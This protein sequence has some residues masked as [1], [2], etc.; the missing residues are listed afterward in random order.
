MPISTAAAT[1]E[2][3]P[4]VW[5]DL[6]TYDYTL[7][8]EFI[9]PLE[10]AVQRHGCAPQSL[11]LALLQRLHW[12]FT[13]DLRSRAPT[14]ALTASQAPAFHDRVRQ[15]M[16]HIDAATLETL[17]PQQVSTEVRHALLSYQDPVLHSSVTADA[18]DHEQGLVRLSYYVHGDPPTETF[19]IDEV[20]VAPAYAKYR[21]C[22]YYHRIL[23]RQRIVWL[24]V[25]SA[26][27][28]R[29]TLGGKLVPLAV[30]SQPFAVGSAPERMGLTADEVLPAARA[31]YPPGKGGQQP[32]PGGWRG[33][34]VRLLLGL[35]RL[36]WARQKFARAWVFA[37]REAGADDNA[38]HLYR[39]VREHHPEINAWFMLGRSS[40]DWDRLARDGFRLI[41]EGLTR[42][43]LILNCEHI[44]SSHADYHFGRFD[45]RLYGNALRWRY[46]FLQHGVIQNDLSHWLGPGEF[47]RF[48]TSS[49]AE[50]ESVVGDD[51]AYPY[52]DR[53]VRRT[54]LPRH[55][56]LLQ[57]A[58]RTPAA[59]VNTLLVMPTWRAG[60][61]DERVAQSSAAGRMAAFAA[62]EYAKHWRALL[63]NDELHDLAER[64]GQRIVFMPH[65]DAAPYID[66]FD[67]PAGVSV[68]MARNNS[69]Q[70][71]FARSAGF[72]TDYTSVAFDMAFLRRPVFYYQ[73]DRE[74]F[75]S[76]GH[77]WREGYFD[78]QR[79]G[80]G[81][82]ALTE[83]ELLG[84]LR[85]YFLNEAKPEPG[86]L[87]RMERA[88]PGRDDQACRRVFASILELH[89]PVATARPEIQLSAE[90]QR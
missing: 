55:D 47:D 54:G 65:F 43:L 3:S 2:P 69:L 40:P 8:R 86:Y 35:A 84:H 14:V 66:A 41:P 10:E 87:A 77:N 24:S 38:E 82:L 11:Q 85:R 90:G 68:L 26:K 9:A 37:D 58:Q 36:P 32:L 53:E 7:K 22:S 49:P 21:A 59:Q 50:H 30:G 63:R 76:G 16:R 19:M 20:A 72:I 39:W 57:I 61:I 28:L 13:V 29:V 27:R 5:R 74:R 33:L 46:T 23:L 45:R 88:M 64:H 89:R 79:D 31:A 12:Y 51:T 60:L 44:I 73:F 17:D 25:G 4:D 34:K 15:I 78:Y 6:A 52:T 1:T 70:Q 81:P 71:T 83:S 62:S 75:Y 56:R 67:V 48:L 18:Y 42:R 80:F